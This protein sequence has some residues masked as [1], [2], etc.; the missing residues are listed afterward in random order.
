MKWKR[1]VREA[2]CAA[3]ICLTALCG[4]N[5]MA[6]TVNSS[7]PQATGSAAQW[8]TKFELP[9]GELQLARRTQPGRFFMSTGRRA[10]VYGFEHGGM[11][12][13]A[14]PL[15]LVDDVQ[16]SF[17]LQG[18]PLDISARDALA[19]IEVRPEMTTLVYSH[20]AFTIRQHIFAAIDQPGVVMLFDVDS[21]LPL[22][23]TGAFRPSLRL[24]W[25]AGSMTPGIAWD[26][27][28][29]LYYLTEETQRFA[30]IVGAP[31]AADV[32]VLPYQEEP[33][34]LPATFRVEVTPERA[35]AQ[36]L[37]VII[38]GGV[39]GRTAAKSVYESLLRNAR[40]EYE[41]ARA[42]YEELD[43]R[44]TKIRT[45]DARLNRAFA[46]AK[47]GTEKGFATNPLFDATGLLAGFRTSGNSERPGFAWYFGRDALWT[48][49]ALNAT[50]DFAGTRTALD[51][52]T[53]FQRADG[54]IPH[55]IS[56]SA[57]LIKW[58]TD[59]PYAWASADATP[60]YV[61]AHADLWQATGDTA[62]LRR[63]WENIKRAYA[64]TARTD[65]DANGLVENTNVGHGWVEG[66][67]LYPPH[68]EIYQQGVWMRASSEIA[69]LA[70]VMNDST[71]A[72]EARANYERTRAS[73]ERIMWLP[74]KGFYAY[75]TN[76]PLAE[77]PVAGAG[78]NRDV[79]QRRMNELNAR[80]LFDENTVLPAV[81]LMW[82]TLEDARAQSE[83]DHLAS[84][85]I[86][87]DWG[88]RIIAND[89]LLYDPLSYHHG[90][91]W[92]LF[93]GW[94]SLGGYAY[95]RPHA[96]FQALMANALL[97]E[98]DALGSVTELLS[99]DFNRAFGRS[100][101]HQIWSEAMVS[102]PVVRGLFGVEIRDGGTTLRFSPQL[103]ANWNTASITDVYA[104]DESYDFNFARETGKRRIAVRRRATKG[105]DAVS[106]AARANPVKVRRLIVVP[107]LPLDAT[108]QAV[109]VNNRAAQ[110]K[111]VRQGDVQRIEIEVMNPAESLA[112]ELSVAE[113][114]EVYVTPADLMTGARSTGLRVIRANAGEANRLR[115]V[116]EGVGGMSYTL[117][118]RT[119]HSMTLA[120]GSRAT[121]LETNTNGER[122][123]RASFPPTATPHTYVR[124]EFSINLR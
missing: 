94:A 20:A 88:A 10:A 99:G 111:S 16:F 52:L 97:T 102:L 76:R 75:A 106:S 22:T 29:R 90:S 13:W 119:P 42:H 122:N 118:L 100:S 84:G 56:Q 67:A 95:G 40:S 116:L 46:W 38:A 17:R 61:I 108:V 81:P 93:T 77:A 4:T 2:W 101:H 34:D 105:S 47:V 23:L 55:E 60:L 39:D 12:A 92:G 78:V 121:L 120:E 15:K 68:E 33:R 123:L 96:G 3:V 21:V 7:N 48:A 113:G 124:Q 57:P 14:Y 70:R 8:V 43:R 69:E 26:E 112:I 104:G 45:P 85:R 117:K 72:V 35:R 44:T 62:T 114:T 18:Y 31:G 63:N 59:Y 51:F 25:P 30:A 98:T 41:Q 83:I 50:G 6:Q 110:F 89:S 82:N 49:L 103:P 9:P 24:M 73:V 87:T 1:G 107:A 115:L 11:E 58:F 109:T 80:T 32:S 54:K 86:A 66:G 53:K 28:E 79:R 65:T 19:R 64:F 27:R 91:V 74:E 36:F 5:A 37:P 71:L